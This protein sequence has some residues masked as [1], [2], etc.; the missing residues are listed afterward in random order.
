MFEKSLYDLI[1][2]LRNH[3]GNERAYIQDC[4][5]ECRREIKTEDMDLKATALLKLTYL[6][7][8]GHDMSWA[9]FNVLEV[10]S[11][12]KY[13]QKRVG[14]LGAVQS[15]RP[16]TEVLMLAENLLKKDLTSP[17]PPTISL[18]LIAIPHVISAS[19]ANSLLSDLIPRLSHSHAN[20][21]K[22]TVV[23]L[24][25]LAL[26]YPE[27]LRPAWPKIKDRL[28]DE[29]EDASVTA[30][31]VNVVCELGWRRPQDFLPLAP[32]L[33]DLLVEGSNNWMA[34]K[35]IKLF[36][37]L[38]P[39][40]PRLIKKLLPPLTSIMQSTPAMSLLYECINGIITGGILNN[41]LGTTEGDD[42]ARLCVYKLRGMLLIEGDPNLRY[43]ALLAFN[44][45]AE[46]HPDLVSQHEDAIM[47]CIDVPDISIRLRA[48]E[49]IVNMVNQQNLTSIVDRLMQQLRESPL[50]SHAE[51]PS[52]DRGMHDRVTPQ[53]D[54]D[55]EEMQQTIRPD[56]RTNRNPP[57]P[58]DYRIGIIQK[59]L[60]MCSRD[61]YANISDF[62]WYIDV[63]VSLVRHVPAVSGT[64][65]SSQDVY[66]I[67]ESVAYAIGIE[68]RNVSAR[69]K[70]ARKEGTQAAEQLISVSRKSQ[71]FPTAGTGGQPVLGPAAWIVGEFAS[72][73]SDR[74]AA[75]TSII[76][77]DTVQ[78]PSSVLGEYIQA[79]MKVL[80]HI[81]GDDQQVWTAERKTMTSLLL[82][83]V[84]HF[85]EPLA[86]HPDLEIQELSTEYLELIR[87]ANEATSAHGIETDD[88]SFASA[89]LVLI[90]AMPSLFSGADLNPL[91]PDAQSKVPIP[92]SLD[93]SLPINEHLT[94]LLDIPD[95]DLDTDNDDI[96][97]NTY[98]FN[99]PQHKTVIEPAAARLQ[100]AE[101]PLSY[102]YQRSASADTLD[103]ETLAR[104]RADRRERNRDDPFYIP[105]EADSGTARPMGELLR[106]SNGDELDVD[107]IPIMA[108]EL[109]SGGSGT[110]DARN[111]PELA[112]TAKK[113]TKA[114]RNLEILADEDL[115][116]S[117]SSTA[118]RALS[119]PASA[120]SAPKASQASRTKS[121]LL[122]VD[123][124]GLGALS[125]S[126][127]SNTSRGARTAQ[128]DIE[129][130]EAEEVEMTAA[131]KEVER[132]RLEMQRAQERI[133][134]KEETV[135]VRKKR[136]KQRV[137]ELESKD[138]DGPEGASA[139]AEAKV[140]RKQKKKSKEEG[141]D[142]K[143]MDATGGIETAHLD[144]RQS[145]Q[146][147]K[148][149][150][151]RREV[152]FD[153]VHDDDDN[154]V[155][156]AP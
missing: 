11:S 132:L 95:L 139:D 104:R 79:A 96:D 138:G 29:T 142:G 154:A 126:D 22:K 64:T 23:T 20:I 116:A 33:F 8:F 85:L 46:L 27:T 47:E 44:R 108:L 19:M 69:V 36:A 58:D 153:D 51:N 1:R 24:Y 156:T 137:I 112:R 97:F 86:S 118:Q 57:L 149:K 14:Y 21:R 31:V 82:A 73:L 84:I 127:P 106:T 151:K 111:Q 37:T 140:K 42:L 103:P 128:L 110:G 4:L 26:V 68:L 66:Q 77:P 121:S 107:S 80:T 99:Q 50:S 9:S 16:D 15:F 35:I 75:L 150:K 55:D 52:N 28:M 63:L 70:S 48:L 49:L 6:E 145:L 12:Q 54:S 40:E 123:S 91:A 93:L 143:E 2:G 3:K 146:P 135:V 7:M 94:T 76:H 81:V 89:P 102:S 67:R 98:Y 100:L 53:A 109:D 30:A 72:L 141:E 25:R 124:S 41:S 74:D 87:L 131:M 130:R 155:S 133:E 122:Q 61:I 129:R 136:R 134:S 120:Q 88:G 13:A 17:M 65:T 5:R 115:D 113:K 18:P 105:S 45:I 101:G 148:R 144:V 32:R 38:I 90:H 125:L 60:S 62:E 152:R 119:M 71:L 117:D 10:M 39:L 78:L 147:K 56:P 83:R 114:R 59:I 92:Y 34:I 43:V